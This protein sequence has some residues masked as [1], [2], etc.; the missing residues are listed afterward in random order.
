MFQKFSNANANTFAKGFKRRARK[1]IHQ[2]YTKNWYM[3]WYK[4]WQ[5]NISDSNT[6]H[7]K[8]YSMR[9][10]LHLANTGFSKLTSES[11]ARQ[12]LQ[13]SRQCWRLFYWQL[14]LDTWIVT[15]PL[16]SCFISFCIHETYLKNYNCD[17]TLPYRLWSKQ[18]WEPQSK[19]VLPQ[20]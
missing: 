19:N 20:L 13:L 15:R 10:E 11:L 12:V 16:W 17:Y 3:F 6:I 4:M 8:H 9:L 7:T 18:S 14:R 2:F 5:Y 1:T